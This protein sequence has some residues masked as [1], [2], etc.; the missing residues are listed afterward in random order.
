[1]K[2]MMWNHHCFQFIPL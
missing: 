2:I 1:V